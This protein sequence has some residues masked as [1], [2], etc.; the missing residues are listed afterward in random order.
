MKRAR[1]FGLVLGLIFW[2]LPTPV[3]AVDSIANCTLCITEIQTIGASGDE[4]EDFVII[5]NSTSAT[6]SLSS[7]RLQYLNNLGELEAAYTT[8]STSGST[9]LTAGQSKA[10]VS[11][12]SEME[13]SNP[14]AGSLENDLWSGGG[15]LRL[16]KITSTTTSPPYDQVS[17]GTA[18]ISEGIPAPPPTQATTLAR[19]TALGRT[20]VDT[21]INQN[22]F[23]VVPL[24]CEAAAVNEI[25]P[26]VTDNIGQGI[27]AWVELRGIATPVGNCFLY[28]KSG[29][30]YELNASDMPAAGE[31]ATFIIGDP[32]GQLWLSD[33]S[34]YGGAAAVNI[35]FASQSFTNMNKGQSWALDGGTWKRTYSPTLGTENIFTASLPI[36]DDPTACNTVRITEL[37]PNPVGDEAGNEWIE[38]Y[39]DSDSPATLDH[40]EVS[41]AGTIYNFLPDDTLGPH[42]WRALTSLYTSDG[43]DKTISLRNTDETQ[44]SLL[45]IRGDS[46][47]D[48]IQSF[49]YSNAP[50]DESWARFASEWFWTYA[51]T[52]GEDNVLQTSAPV[53]D[54]T[55]FAGTVPGDSGGGKGAGTSP[56]L[57][58]TELLPNPDAPQ[59]DENDEF[60]ELYNP[61]T[62]P[63]VLDGYKVQTGS[64]YTYSFTIDS[65][66]IPAGGYLVL[67]SGGTGL[68]LANTAGRARL[69]DPSGAVISETDPYEDAGEGDAWALIDGKW[70]W[71]SSPTEGSANVLT[72]VL[73][74]SS[75]TAA[76][77]TTAKTTASKP[78]ATKASAVKSTKTTK[79]TST[80][81]S[82]E[83]NSTKIPALH[84]AVLVGAAVLAVVYAVY[85][86]RQDAANWIYKLKRNRATRRAGRQ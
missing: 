18:A 73:S 26:F 45:R 84:P 16:I 72:A 24:A 56:P 23:D 41:V 61:N 39:N 7:V 49:V 28:T 38:F 2:S 22:D 80:G 86:Y 15:T 81:S 78:K 64:N 40:C 47:T 6:I 58:I 83:N 60:I 71:T 68:T 74:G 66:T 59:T 1:I 31:L 25:Q 19:K 33:Q 10:F 54:V 52:P 63:V 9:S 4:T 5:T 77:K 70:Q 12:E 85:E 67:T 32:G 50:E 27:D 36:V 30:L 42:E 37:Y 65:Q 20:I 8:V 43:V 55:E 35:P 34:Q 29:N 69:L 44:V 76:K 46:S 17:W 13:N 62:E 82:Q 75:S 14:S 79:P 11:T 51:L 48:T 53:P 57:S 21:N 3:Y